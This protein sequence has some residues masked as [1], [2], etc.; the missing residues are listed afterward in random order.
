[1]IQKHLEQSGVSIDVVFGLQV[2]DRCLTRTAQMADVMGAA[3]GPERSRAVH[4]LL[5]RLIQLA[6]QDRS[7][8]H[9]VRWNLHLLDRKIVDRTGQTGEH[10]VAATPSEYRHIW[11]AA[12]GAGRSPS[13]RRP[14]RCSSTSGTSPPSRRASSTA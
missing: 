4:R 8:L 11:L 13:S 2:I 5:A 3:E 7:V 14:S 10:Y 1:M 12:A 6:H 9:L